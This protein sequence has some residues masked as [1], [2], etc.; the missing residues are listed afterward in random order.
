MWPIPCDP[1]FPDHGFRPG[2]LPEFLAFD[3]EASRVIHGANAVLLHY[4]EGLRSVW[5]QV[6]SGQHINPDPRDQTNPFPS[7][8]IFLTGRGKARI[9]GTET[10]IHGGTATLIP[11]G[12]A[13]EFW[14]RFE[15]PLEFILIMFGQGA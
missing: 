8:F 6:E 1:S 5:Y 13:H 2:G 4:F 12:V 15:Q 3:R 7:L 14:N 10:D 11:A 9:G